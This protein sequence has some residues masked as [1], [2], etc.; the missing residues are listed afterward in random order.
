MSRKHTRRQFLK[1][2]AGATVATTL[3]TAGHA[4]QPGTS[5]AASGKPLAGQ[6]IR[7]LLIDTVYTRA[8]KDY[9]PEFEAMTGA[10]VEYDV[11]AFVIA[12]Q[13][14]DL[15]LSGGTGSY[16]VVNMTFIWSGKW[17]G[18]NWATELT[19]LVDDPA[20]TDKSKLELSDF[21]GLST[22]Q[23]GNRLYALPYF[24]E[25]QLLEYRTD[26]FQKYNIVKPPETFDEMIAI[27]NKVHSKEVAGNLLRGVAALHFTWPAFLFSYGGAFF[28][29]PPQDMTPLLNSPQAVAAT[30]TYA[31]LHRFYPGS[32]SMADADTMTAFSQGKAAMWIDGTGVLSAALDPK[33][34]VVHDKV[35]FAQVPA[36]PAGRKP[37]MAVHGM[38]IPAAA[39][40]K[41][42]GWEFIKWA[43]SKE[44][45]SRISL[46]RGYIPVPRDSI[47][48]SSEYRKR[49]TFGNT[50]LGTLQAEG[51]RIA[52]KGAYMFYRTIPEFGPM[53][54]RIVIAMGEVITKQRE[55]KAAL[56]A[57]NK[58]VAEIMERAGHKVRKG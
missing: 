46:E 58:D 17:I 25:V 36:G 55:T 1:M 16:D 41:H 9:I 33:R 57:L 38:L 6:T 35:S 21:V 19:P 11:Q 18:A 39:K 51:G 43:I 44:L 14:I 52:D 48:A 30:E 26:I 2:A 23:R 8:I 15:E 29:N 12:N 13:R 50:D 53:G 3:G 4:A 31:T 20:L 22:F 37:Q 24:A 45:M 56:D 28:A 40:E 32:V 7:C 47:L 27:A 34:S 5:P 42:K 54:D 10:K 49:F